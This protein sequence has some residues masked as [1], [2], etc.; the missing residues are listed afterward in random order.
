MSLHHR[1]ERSL[2]SSQNW[3][4]WRLMQRSQTRPP[5]RPL[6]WHP[7]VLF[8]PSTP[9]PAALT[10]ETDQRL[11][12]PPSRPG[13]PRSDWGFRAHSIAPDLSSSGRCRGQFEPACPGAVRCSSP[14]CPHFP[15]RWAVQPARQPWGRPTG[16]LSAS[17]LSDGPQPV[18]FDE[19]KNSPA[20]PRPQPPHRANPAL[21]AE[22]Q[23]SFSCEPSPQS[24][25]ARF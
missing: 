17:Q 22:H 6:A 7:A 1:P 13:P 18:L 25:R 16:M 11:A 4:P 5:M 2:R 20:K 15:I 23:T 19:A 8:Q 9:S 10:A 12:E 24:N 21:D 14:A 3:L